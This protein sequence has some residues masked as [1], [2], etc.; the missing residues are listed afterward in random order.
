VVHGDSAD[1]L[2][3]TARVAGAQRDLKGIGV[4]LVDA[5]DPG[6][7]RR[8]YRTVDG[9]RAAEVELSNARALAVLGNPEDG[10]PLVDQVVDEHRG[11]G[12]RGGG[13]CRRR[14]T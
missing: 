9:Q 13:P 3:V 5:K 10:L 8:G 4:F 11:A 14:T 7:Q 6:V 2:I 1:R 12:R